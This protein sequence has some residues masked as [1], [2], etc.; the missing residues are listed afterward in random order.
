MIRETLDSSTEKPMAEEPK[1][2]LGEERRKLPSAC[3]IPFEFISYVDQRVKRE[4]QEVRAQ[5]NDVIERI[6]ANAKASEERHHALVQQLTIHMGRQELVEQAFLRT[7]EGHPDFHGHR[8]DHSSR[9]RAAEWWRGVRDK[10]TIK[11]IEW[12]AVAVVAWVVL[13]M[14]EGVLRGPR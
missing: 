1:P 5:Y 6:D 3:A 9:M 11:L 7:D 8:N 13:L 4:L 10:T 12:S 2:W 14:W